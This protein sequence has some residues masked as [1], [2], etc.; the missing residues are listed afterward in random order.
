MV[1]IRSGPGIPKARAPGAYSLSKW[2]RGIL[3]LDGSLG[4]EHRM[5]F[6][7]LNSRGI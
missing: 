3:W 6:S 1:S 5:A 2:G 7:L 4:F